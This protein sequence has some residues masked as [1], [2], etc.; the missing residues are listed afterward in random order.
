MRVVLDSNIF[1]STFL[2]GSLAEEILRFCNKG[3]IN[4]SIS[5]EIIN[6][7]IHKLHQKFKIRERDIKIFANLITSFS[8]K[9]APKEKV[10]SNPE[11]PQ[12]N[13]ILECA[14]AAQADLI[15][16]LDH[17]L[18]KIKKFKNIT[19]IHPKTLTWMIPDY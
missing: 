11:D 13:K 14:R 7:I 3:I 12:D 17:H 6:E 5:Q 19:L 16:T 10:T 2:K 8:Q 9:V 15:I 4:N 18:L 1:I